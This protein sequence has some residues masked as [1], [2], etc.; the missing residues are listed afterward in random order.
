MGAPVTFLTSQVGQQGD[1]LDGLAEPHFVSQDAVE[2]LLVHGNQP[3]Q[4]NVLVLPQLAPQ[5]QGD[6][7]LHL[8]G[9]QRVTFGLEAFGGGSNV[10]DFFLRAQRGGGPWGGRPAAPISLALL[11]VPGEQVFHS[12]VIVLVLILICLALWWGFLGLV[13]LGLLGF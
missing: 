6:G 8:G 11:L 5:E 12:E 7:C 9:G 13:R 4:P 1:G 3:V 2:L 10:G